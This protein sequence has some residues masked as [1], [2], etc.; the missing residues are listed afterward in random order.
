MDMPEKFSS[1][2]MNYLAP[3]LTG[4]AVGTA[5]GALP[6]TAGM[7]RGLI[8]GLS[9]GAG[10][11]GGGAIADL[12]SARLGLTPELALAL[13]LAGRATGGY[14]GY[15]VARKYTKT[16][17]EDVYDQV[18]AVEKEQSKMG[19]AQLQAMQEQLQAMKEQLQSAAP[20]MGDVMR[21][22]TVSNMV[23][24][25]LSAGVLGTGLLGS[26]PGALGGAIS[27]RGSGL[28]PG[29][30]RGFG[31]GAG[32]SLGAMGG[33]Y[34][35]EKFFGGDSRA[36]ALGG[37]LGGLAGGGLGYSAAKKLTK[38]RREQLEDAMLDYYDRANENGGGMPV[39]PPAMLS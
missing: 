18:E 7:K 17:P 21:Q 19:N 5:Y 14:G 10:S 23:A 33:N 16:R 39:M 28:L 13:N 8:R 22:S 29:A 6:H 2:L 9:A 37:L 35:A 15:R 24:K 12:I 27:P 4:G 34:L 20:S 38:T 25:L 30:A 36:K 32:A 26:I 11:I 31:V 3:L 1:P